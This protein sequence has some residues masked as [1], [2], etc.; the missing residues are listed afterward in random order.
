MPV[1]PD[2]GQLTDEGRRALEAARWDEAREAFESVLGAEETPD[3]LA[4]LGLALWFLGDVT[5]GVAARERAV[6]GYVRTERCDEA[7]RVAVWVSHQHFVAGRVSA[8]RGWLA[9]AERAVER[10]GTCPGQGW[11]A[12]ERARHAETVEECAA[13]A[14]RAMEIAKETNADDLEVFAVSLLGRAE[15]SAGRR[16]EGMR[17]LEEAM[18]AASAGRVSNVHTLAEAYCNLIAACTSAGDWERATEWCELVDEFARTHETAPLYGA[19]RTIHAD[20]LL[21]NGRWDD[22]E[23]A[24][25]SAL[26]VHAR[27]VPQ[28]AAPT[29]AAMAELRVRQ[30]RLPEAEQLLVGRE[31]H[32]ESLRALAH[33]RL[34]QG[35]P[36]VAEALLERGLL[37]AE[38]DAVQ[39]GQLFALLVDAQLARGDADSADRTARLLA[40]LAERSANAVAAARAQLATA[41]VQLETG[42]TGDA[43]ESARRALASFGRL[44][45][46]YEVAEARLVLARALAQASPE[47]AAEEARA[48]YETFRELG[49]SRPR[50]EAAAV[51]RDLG[52]P[53]GGLPRAN[54]ELTAREHEVLALLTAGL[55]NA[56]IAERLVISEKTAGHHVS[57]ILAKLGVRNRVEAAAL[58]AR[59]ATR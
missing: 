27:Y 58:A 1:T 17:L 55:S 31:E 38:D 11:V 45:M 19:C 2:V 21:A 14:R 23:R 10:A 20:V 25:Q 16:E 34:A 4:G 37:A 56:Q 26:D 15:V 57:H 46:P 28:L 51:L 41:R 30:G 35:Q 49:A 33:L 54:G 43:A 13:H 12:V 59:S 18:A 52:V 39:T 8:A 47:L 53:T 36:Q 29:V 24:L 40:E 50:D 22:A 6:E 3:A 48:A 7:A 32:P 9:R 42:L 5:A 44:T